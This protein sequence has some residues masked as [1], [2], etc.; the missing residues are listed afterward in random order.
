M[1]ATWLFLALAG[2]GGGLDNQPVG[3]DA[4]DGDAV[5]DGDDGTG[6]VTESITGLWKFD[7]MGGAGGMTISDSSG[8]LEVV[9]P[10][11]QDPAQ[12]TWLPTSLRV[13]SPVVISTPPDRMPL[14]DAVRVTNEATL[15]AWVTATNDT[16]TG[17]N[18]QP[19]RIVSLAPQNAGN[20]SISLGQINTDWVAGAR[21]D[22]TDNNG[23]PVLRQPVMVGKSTH[24][25][26][27]V[28]S[29]GRKFYV[30]GVVVEDALGG[31]LT[32]PDTGV[33]LALASEPNPAN[34]LNEWIGTF[35]VVAMYSQALDEAEVMRNFMA[36]PTF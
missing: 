9:T 19:A 5:V 17:T 28:N 11:I 18:G 21:T 13:N 30:D 6:R 25:V 22:M 3:V 34:P 23:G 35:H 20:H 14:I 7:D 10:T 15:E 33:S 12:V 16:Q 24:L 1:R 31:T 26:V 36:G 27:T 2:C 32:W 4:P 8:A 29:T